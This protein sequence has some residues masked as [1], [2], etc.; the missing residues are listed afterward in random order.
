[1]LVGGP[2]EGMLGDESHT[3]WPGSEQG[4]RVSARM[5]AKKAAVRPGRGSGQPATTWLGLSV[6]RRWEGEKEGVVGS[7][8]TQ[9]GAACPRG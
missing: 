9:G 4:R 2:R 5:G 6:N 1:M 3:A 7:G 8:R